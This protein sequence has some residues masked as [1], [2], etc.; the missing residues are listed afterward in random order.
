MTEYI[1]E[2]DGIRYVTDCRVFKESIDRGQ[3]EPYPN[4]LWVVQKYLK[5]NPHKNRT[6]VDVG[7][8]IGTTAIPYSRLYRDVIAYEANP[9]NFGY[10]I[11]NVES[12]GIRN[13]TCVSKG[14]YNEECHGNILCHGSNSGCFYFA[15][16]PAGTVECT[17]LD[18]GGHSEVDFVKIDVE[19]AELFVLQGGEATLRQWKPL[20]HL[21]MNGLCEKLY[22]VPQAD[23]LNW[24]QSLGYVRYEQPDQDN[25]FFWHPDTNQS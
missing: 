18:A 21:E 14:L 8:H 6:Y 9:K 1:A 17:T 19:G 23:L 16:D 13:V 4:H 15:K 12:N 5:E 10:L 20:V 22:G 7:G 11:R 25:V 3:S 24:I 2:Y